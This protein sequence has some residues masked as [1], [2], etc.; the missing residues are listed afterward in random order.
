MGMKII[1]GDDVIV[2]SGKDKG[3]MGKVIKVLRK[4]HCGKDVSFAVVS[5][6]NIC[7]KSVKATQKNDGGIVSVEKPINLSNIALFDST[8]GIRTRVGYKFINEKKVRF[9]KS[10]GKVIE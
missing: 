4:K 2:I 5:G 10:S 3:K 9:M 1:V 6:V 7:K 8:L